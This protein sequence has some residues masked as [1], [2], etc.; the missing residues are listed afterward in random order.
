[1]SSMWIGQ[2]ERA[3]WQRRAAAELAAILDAHDGLPLI[4]WTVG[5]AGSVLAGRVS[6]LFPAAQARE[7]FAAW[8]KGLALGD[9]REDQMSGGTTALHAAARGREVTVRLTVTVYDDED[10]DL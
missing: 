2:A 7:V 10:G 5:P 8:Q 1:V 3:A 9:A 4:T 6:G